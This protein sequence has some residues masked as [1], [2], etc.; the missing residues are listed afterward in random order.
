MNST[1]PDKQRRGAPR[2]PLSV[3][4]AIQEIVDY[5]WND[6][7]MDYSAR[8]KDDRDGHVF[9]ECLKVRRFLNRIGV[10]NEQEHD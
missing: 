4:K 8:T 9:R 6:E 1:R 5:L 10:V 7:F 3:L 2:I